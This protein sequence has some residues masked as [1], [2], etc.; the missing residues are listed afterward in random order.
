MDT[1][2]NWLAIVI[3]FC[4]VVFNKEIANSA[5]ENYYKTIHKRYRIDQFRF[6]MYLVGSG[7]LICGILGLFHI[8]NFNG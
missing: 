2:I 4:F 8:I 6:P 5:I 7:V 3:G 1:L